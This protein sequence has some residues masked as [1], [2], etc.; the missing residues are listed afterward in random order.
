[1][2]RQAAAFLQSHGLRKGDRI[3]LSARTELDFIYVY[4]RFDV[5]VN[6]ICKRFYCWICEQ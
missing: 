1:M 6:F 3:A 4:F 2:N 5:I